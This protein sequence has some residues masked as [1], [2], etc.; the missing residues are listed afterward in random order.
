MDA[1]TSQQFIITTVLAIVLAPFF[2]LCALQIPKRLIAE[3]HNECIEFLRL[4]RTK[5]AL[6]DRLPRPPQNSTHRWLYY[7]P[8]ISYISTHA[9]KQK[10]RAVHPEQRLFMEMLSITAVIITFMQYGWTA[11]GLAMTYFT[12]SLIAIAF[13]DANSKLIPDVLSVST[14]WV[15]LIAATLHAIDTPLPSAIWGA[16]AGYLGPYLISKLVC[17][18]NKRPDAMGYGDFKMLAMF[19]V[20]L[21][22]LNTLNAVILSSLLFL[23]YFVCMQC[24]GRVSRH[25]LIP[26]G[27]FLSIA[28]WTIC[29]SPWFLFS[30]YLSR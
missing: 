16:I 3:Y 30:T 27:P 17:L 18:R 6:P 20:W 11:P 19:G 24:A 9:E 8:I 25:S 21:G 7:F 22:P 2:T 23:L 26:F 29:Q 15:G 4:K 28:A 10:N 5:K 14:L 1:L 13:I 12:L